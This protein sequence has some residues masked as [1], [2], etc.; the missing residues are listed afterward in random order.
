[1]M[2]FLRTHHM[3]RAVAVF[4]RFYLGAFPEGAA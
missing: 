3:A 4:S 2:G 1:M